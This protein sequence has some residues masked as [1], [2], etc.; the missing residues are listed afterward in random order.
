MKLEIRRDRGKLLSPS[1]SNYRLLSIVR[2]Q[3]AVVANYLEKKLQVI[4]FICQL[5]IEFLDQSHATLSPVIFYRQ[6]LI[7]CFASLYSSSSSHSDGSFV[8]NVCGILSRSNN[9]L[10]YAVK[11]CSNPLIS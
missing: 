4:F 11:N 10:E 8:R 6:P 5:T 1:V 9:F 7:I 3:F 2:K